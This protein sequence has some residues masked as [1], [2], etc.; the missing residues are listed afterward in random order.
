MDKGP[1][2]PL[3]INEAG[4]P[5]TKTEA[6]TTGCFSWLPAHPGEKLLRSIGSKL[7]QCD[8]CGRWVYGVRCNHAK[9]PLTPPVD[10]NDN[11]R[12]PPKDETNKDVI[13]INDEAQTGG[14]PLNT[15]RVLPRTGS[16]PWIMGKRPDIQQPNG[17]SDSSDDDDSEERV[18]KC[19]EQ[20]PDNPKNQS[21]ERLKGGLEGKSKQQNKRRDPN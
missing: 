21:A 20:Y 4:T 17:H 16:R 3:T 8:T 14:V 2:E 6:E 18:L 19:Y 5:D 13:C 10:G 11:I 12:A 7:L 1:P 15:V 9:T